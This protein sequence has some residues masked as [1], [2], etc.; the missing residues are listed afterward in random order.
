MDKDPNP[1]H[2]VPRTRSNFSHLTQYEACPGITVPKNKTQGQTS[3]NHFYWTIMVRKPYSLPKDIADGLLL[4]FIARGKIL[5][6][7]RKRQTPVPF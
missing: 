7:R 6:Q 3:S 5:L 1:S 4:G 2:Q